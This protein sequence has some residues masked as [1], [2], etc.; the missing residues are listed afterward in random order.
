VLFCVLFVCKCVLCCCH[1]VSTELQITNTSC[2][3]Q[4]IWKRCA[5]GW[6]WNLYVLNGCSE[7]VQHQILNLKAWMHKAVILS[8]HRLCKSYRT[9]RP[10]SAET[11]HDSCGAQDS[12]ER[13]AHCNSPL[14]ICIPKY[15]C[16][17]FTFTWPCIVTNFLIIKPTR[18]TNCYKSEGRRFDS[19]WCHW[20][21]SLT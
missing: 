12:D 11:Y 8:L 14:Q 21:F 7:D 19:R 15:H 16:A 17:N 9:K 20:N 10:A 5:S 13:N 18:C 2:T 1:R 3:K 4:Q 6:W